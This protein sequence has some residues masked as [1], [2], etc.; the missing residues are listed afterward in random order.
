MVTRPVCIYLCGAPPAPIAAEHGRF[1]DWFRRLLADHPLDAVEV[2]GTAGG[3]PPDPA[4]FAAVVIS[5]SP[6]SVTEPEPWMDAAAELVRE[7]MRVGAPLLGVCF[8][9]QIAAAALGGAVRVN[10]RGWEVGTRAVELTAD[11]RAD[12][13]FDGIGPHLRVNFSHRDVVDPESLPA[14]GCRV[15]AGNDRSEAQAFAAG[16]AVRCVQF[17]PEFDGAATR[18]YIRTRHDLLAA[19]A[20]ARGASG[21]HPDALLA[22]TA[23]TPDGERV[24]HNFIR[25]WAL[26]A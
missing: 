25:H 6:A 23:D 17:H 21:D 20:A 5:G 14:P 18:A 9:H 12:P 16:D 2:D 15:L 19:D 11:G 24:F 1:A 3:R 13:L 26:K 22:A 7:A 10:P 4:D 8:G